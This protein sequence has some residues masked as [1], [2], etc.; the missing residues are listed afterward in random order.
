MTA[1]STPSA[2]THSDRLF[3]TGMAVALALTVFV[4]FAPTYFLK[5]YFGAPPLPALAH[6]HGAVFTAWILL[7]LSQTVLISA[8]RT[9]VHRKLGIFGAAL[10]VV[11]LTLG[12][13]TTVA[14]F[15]L[16]RTPP[17]IDPRAFLVLP[18]GDMVTFA[19]LVGFGIGFRAQPELHKRL[20]LLAT[21]AMLDAAIARL[22][23]LFALGPIAFFAFQDLFVLAGVVYDFASRRRIHPVYIWGGLFIVVMQAVRLS[24]SQT[25]W[26]LAFGDWLKG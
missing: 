14:A 20:M 15:R 26:W 24:V 12:L 7:F 17:G 4:G 18:F 3:Y 1:I 5:G 21:V 11:V 16:G 6:V 22:P 8:G 13:V 2:R 10:A 25:S 19:V 9:D 23:G